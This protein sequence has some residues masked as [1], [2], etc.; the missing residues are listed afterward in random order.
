MVDILQHRQTPSYH[1][2]IVHNLIYIGTY[3]VEFGFIQNDNAFKITL[4]R[5]C[6]TIIFIVYYYEI[7]YARRYLFTNV[8]L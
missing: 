3:I 2:Y 1:Y 4:L 8:V 6:P 5:T 7:P